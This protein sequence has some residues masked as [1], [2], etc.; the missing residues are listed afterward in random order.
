MLLLRSGALNDIQLQETEPHSGDSAAGETM[1]GSDKS[2]LCW[3]SLGGGL[4]N[5]HLEL[6][7]RGRIHVHNAS[8][9]HDAI[10]GCEDVIKNGNNDNTTTVTTA[11][12]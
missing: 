5:A 1:N 4:C 12:K 10:G 11:A 9:T 7:A 6:D 3:V 2:I 8:S